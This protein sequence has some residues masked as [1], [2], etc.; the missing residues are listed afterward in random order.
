[1]PKY[2]CA[3]LI[4]LS[5]LLFQSNAPLHAQAPSPIPRQLQATISR[6]IGAQD[7]SVEITVSGNIITVLRINSNMNQSTHGSRGN[8]A[9][10]IAPIM[11]KAIAASPA[12]KTLHTIRVQYVIRSAPAADKVIDTIDFRKDPS[13]SFEF[14]KM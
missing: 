4:A 1:M 6:T 10:A 11:S 3:V 14:H 2:L 12:L 8:E 5:S 7:G 9:N 13:G